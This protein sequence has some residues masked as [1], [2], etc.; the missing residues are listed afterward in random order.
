M[1]YLEKR[2]RE[3]GADLPEQPDSILGIKVPEEPKPNPPSAD[4]NA[5]SARVSYS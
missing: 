3:D 2:K 5:P 1:L 4:T